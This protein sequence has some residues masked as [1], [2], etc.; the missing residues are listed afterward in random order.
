MSTVPETQDFINELAAPSHHTNAQLGTWTR[1]S[2]KVV[3]QQ[4]QQLALLRG[5]LQE[6]EGQEPDAAIGGK[7]ETLVQQI[8]AQVRILGNI[9]RE[10]RAL[11]TSRKLMAEQVKELRTLAAAAGYTVP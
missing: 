7:M 8:D 6:A 1:A 4:G 3:T 2:A 9:A 11:R 10:G 5:Q